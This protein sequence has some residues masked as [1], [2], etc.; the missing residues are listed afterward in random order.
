MKGAGYEA[1]SEP[2]RGRRQWRRASSALWTAAG[3]VA[4]WAAVTL[5]AWLLADLV[6]GAAP[7]LTWRSLVETTQ[8]LGGG[9][10]NAIVGTLWLLFWTALLVAPVGVAAATWGMVWAT[11]RLR[12]AVFLASDVLAGVPSIVFGYVG[13]LALVIGLGW[14]FSALAAAVTLAVLVL[15]Y[16][17]RNAQQA[18]DAVPRER[19]EAALAL[20]FSRA[21]MVWYVLWPEARGG[22][23]TGLVLAL[24]IAMGETA[25][26]LYTAEWSQ[27]LPTWSLTHHAVGYLTYVVWAFVQEPYPQAVALAYLAGLLLTVAVGGI[28]VFTRLGR[29]AE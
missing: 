1:P 7:A 18:L 27:S 22:L 10:A 9:L 11:P 19:Q 24:G 6:R 8:G 16:L 23:A 25:P 14:G 2:A 28:A 21:A 17:V 15:P 4:A 13:Y 3:G 5:V 29:A 26:L 20:G 12:R